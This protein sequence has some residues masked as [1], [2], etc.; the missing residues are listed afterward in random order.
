MVFLKNPLIGGSENL[1]IKLIDFGTAI[2][3]RKHKKNQTGLVGTLYYLAPEI[4][5][6]FFT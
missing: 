5:K 4:A 3:V 2:T 1:E 6:G